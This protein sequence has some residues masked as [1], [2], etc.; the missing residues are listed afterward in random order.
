MPNPEQPKGPQEHLE[1]RKGF[2]DSLNRLDGAMG[3]AP[4]DLPAKPTEADLDAA[5]RKIT[6]DSVFRGFNEQFRSNE[7]I[8]RRRAL[9]QRAQ[10]EK[11]PKS[12][13][14]NE[15]VTTNQAITYH[16]YF[17]AIIRDIQDTMRRYSVL[18]SSIQSVPTSLQLQELQGTMYM[19]ALSRALRERVV[20]ANV[21]LAEG[22]AAK[23]GGNPE[24]LARLRS[25]ALASPDL[26]AESRTILEGADTRAKWV[27]GNALNQQ[28]IDLLSG[29]ASVSGVE[30]GFMPQ[31]MYLELVSLRY[32]QILDE[33]KLVVRSGASADEKNEKLQ[34]LSVERRN[35]TDEL[36]YITD[37]LGEDQM[38]RAELT[39]IQHQFGDTFDF[40]EVRPPSKE[41]TPE[42]I[43]NAMNEQ[44]RQRSEF[45]LQRMD[46]FMGAFEGEVLGDGV[47]VRVEDFS[48]KK[49]RELVQAVTHGL[50]RL[51]TIPV[52]ESFGMKESV[53]NW[54]SEPLDKSLGWPAG[55]DQWEEL[56]SE[57]QANVEK[58]AQSILDAIRAFDRSKIENFRST[59]SLIKT[60]P[61]ADTL[62]G[63][64]PV[65]PLP[66]ERITDANRNELINKY[67]AQTVYLMLFQQ[68]DADWGSEQPPS[69]FIGE[70]AE[71]LGSVNQNIDVHVDVGGALY[72]L[73]ANYDQMKN[74][75]LWIAAAAFVG[76]LLTPAILRQTIR[77]VRSGGRMVWKGGRWILEKAPKGP[78]IAVAAAEAQMAIT[79]EVAQGL[80]HNRESEAITLVRR[81]L[82]ALKKGEDLDG[83][84][85]SPELVDRFA[86]EAAARLFSSLLQINQVEAASPN[87]LVSARAEAT[88]D[89]L[90][91][92]EA[93]VAANDIMAEYG[94]PKALTLTPDM[95]IPEDLSKASERAKAVAAEMKK[96]VPRP[97]TAAE[98]VLKEG[99]VLTH[100][101]MTA[102]TQSPEFALEYQEYEKN[103]NRAQILSLAGRIFRAKYDIAT[104]LDIPTNHP[105]GAVRM[106]RNTIGSKPGYADMVSADR[107]AQLNNE[108]RALSD[109]TPRELLLMAQYLKKNPP[110]NQEILA[111]YDGAGI[112]ER[113]VVKSFGSEAYR[114][115][116]V[117]RVL[118]DWYYLRGHAAQY[119]PK[120]VEGAKGATGEW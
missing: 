94:F 52:P 110:S 61:T 75:L 119:A 3:P 114:V 1:S 28:I 98:L 79:K 25:Q 22:K 67:G 68:L 118:D 26:S 16:E 106:W 104:E 15:L 48:N 13:P 92:F 36:L 117:R 88:P 59:V 65:D 84:K 64:E 77:A 32:K 49:G 41:Q 70:Y 29:K 31:K 83:K 24:T 99:Q 38:R 112:G 34:K 54:L 37:Q 82:E 113:G 63:T 6:S 57:E 8:Y 74:Y 14:L 33:E 103:A 9:E 102:V 7:I 10:M 100:E 111:W 107:F 45:H 76:G 95:K 46:A 23:Q 120:P 81:D 19:D 17:P 116:F 42:E 69:G 96:E 30:K 2:G 72:Q 62:A 60:M 53:R 71:L 89:P 105:T 4:A 51:F 47:M 87:P 109:V 43:R 56:T 78:L 85:L 44:M 12:V 20:F 80:I 11:D 18:R 35:M 91:V 55:K 66:T 27:R 39:T 101:G 40:A 50:A 58:K 115:D 86:K 90:L 108:S 93:F 5:E 73:G 21:V 97:R